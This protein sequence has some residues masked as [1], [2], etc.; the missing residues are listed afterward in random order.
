M[1]ERIISARTCGEEDWQDNN[2]RPRTL[3]EYIGQEKLKS[4]LRIFIAAAR[5]RGDSLDHVLLYGPQIGR[6]HV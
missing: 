6:A 5:E 2:L 1:D 4:N 3:D